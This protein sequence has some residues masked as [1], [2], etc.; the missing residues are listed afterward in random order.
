MLLFWVNY[1]EHRP[2]KNKNKIHNLLH[3]MKMVCNLLYYSKTAKIGSN[4]KNIS[5]NMLPSCGS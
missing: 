1:V 2:N 3:F 5:F 4:F